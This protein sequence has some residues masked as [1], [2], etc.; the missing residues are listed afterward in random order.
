MPKILENVQAIILS[1]T[2][3]A[4]ETQGY[5]AITI[6]SIARRC[7]LATGTIYNY[8]SSKEVLVAHILL[9]DWMKVTQNIHTKL[10][11]VNTVE[12]GIRIIYDAIFAFQRHYEGLFAESGMSMEGSA[13]Q[14]RHNMLIKQIAGQIEELYQKEEI[15]KSSFF[16]EFLAENILL[17]TKRK[18]SFEQLAGCLTI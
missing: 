1:E 10:G 15:N 9:E 5:Q 4:L 3:I 12:D 17:G 11:N 7:G 8:F 2:R 13:F 6:R 18:W 14:S 16:L